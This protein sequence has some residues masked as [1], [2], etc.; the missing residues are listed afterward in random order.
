MATL[1]EKTKQLLEKHVIL[2]NKDLDQHFLINE[3]KIMQLIKNITKT[4]IV[5]EVGCGVGTITQF[6]VKKAKKVIGVEIDK[7]FKPILEVYAKTS[8]LNNLQKVEFHYASIWEVI[9]DIACNKIVANPPYTIAESL[10]K[11]ILGRKDIEAMYLAVPTKFYQ[12]IKQNPLFSAFFTINVILDLEKDD[13]YPQPDTNSTL[14]SIIKRDITDHADKN[15]FL[16]REVYAQKIKKLQNALREA[17]IL[18]ANDA[19][20]KLTKKTARELIIAKKLSQKLLSQRVEQLTA[21]DYSEISF[22]LST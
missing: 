9:D 16:I 11:Y 17:L 7:R 19:E 22:F 20:T 4:D 10:L 13:F 3:E 6:L 18:I 14:I 5:L 15:A 1:K 8:N 21:E 2:L 12:K